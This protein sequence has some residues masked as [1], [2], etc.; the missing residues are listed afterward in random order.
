MRKKISRGT[1]IALVVFGLI[2]VA[3]LATYLTS[4]PRTAVGVKAITVEIVAPPAE[5]KTLALRTDAEF[6]RQ[7]LEEQGLIQGDES[8]YGLFVTS[9]DGIAA[10]ASKQEWWCFTKGGE[11]LFTGVDSTPIQDGD[12]FEIT[13]TTGY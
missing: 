10:D 11:E 9:V 8:A 6:L 5:T 4:R 7:A 2:C 13:L 12:K 3:L 1:V